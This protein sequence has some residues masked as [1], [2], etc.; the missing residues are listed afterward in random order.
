MNGLVRRI[1][2]TIGALLV[3]RFGS[4]I[5][6]ADISTESDLLSSGAVYRVSIFALVL[7][8]YLSAAIV[9]QLLSMVWGSL[10]AL[11]C[12]GKAE[13][14]PITL[15]PTLLLASSQAFGIAPAMQNISGLVTEP[16][17]W[18][19]LSASASMVGGVFFMIWLSEQITRH[20]IGNGIA[21]ILS[22]NIVIAFPAEVASAAELLRQGVVSGNFVLL[23]ALV[24]VSL[25]ATIVLVEGARR[26]MPAQYGARQV[27][28]RLLAPRG[29]ALPIKLNS[30]GFL[31]PVTLAPWIFYQPLALAAMFLGHTPWLTA[32]YEHMQF[33]G[34]A[35]IIRNP[36]KTGRRDPGR[37]AG[38][39]QPRWGV[40]D[41]GSAGRWWGRATL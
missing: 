19:L 9:I 23:N 38:R 30:A 6:V 31:I 4:Q 22:I 2:V 34:P 11:A 32:A 20:G 21:L 12:S 24:W 14:A 10:G 16:G 27:G 35:H 15:I 26:N 7:V 5:P 39:A 41:S 25:V 40:A 3:F 17:G 18:L 8:P 29:L 1:A 37:R 33:A 36:A 13:I 28:K